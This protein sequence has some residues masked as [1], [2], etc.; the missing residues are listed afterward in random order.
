MHDFLSTVAYKPEN[1]VRMIDRKTGETR[2][3]TFEDIRRDWNLHL[4]LEAFSGE[5]SDVQVVPDDEASA[6]EFVEE[7]E[8]RFFSDFIGNWNRFSEGR[9]EAVEVLDADI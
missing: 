8:R 2:I 3:L 6:I 1:R 7:E 9:L 5:M 4:A